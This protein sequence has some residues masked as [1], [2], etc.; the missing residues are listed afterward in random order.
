MNDKKSPTLP[1]HFGVP[2]GSILGPVLFNLYVTDLSDQ[3]SSQSIQY[4]DD[5]TLYRH[6]KIRQILQ[7]IQEVESDIA[8]L[9]TWS[10]DHNLL[11]NPDK[12]QYII[13]STNESKASTYCPSD[14]NRVP[15]NGGNK[16]GTRND[17]DWRDYAENVS[18]DHGPIGLGIQ[19]A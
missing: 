9:D 8:T 17:R 3:I 4:A 14:G 13:F 16:K 19:V 15:R 7:C 5:T 10:T 6:S 12:L 18:S 2:Q 11:F 1:I